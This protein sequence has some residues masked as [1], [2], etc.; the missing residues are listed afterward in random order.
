MEKATKP[1]G[2]DRI[3]KG[4]LIA[5]ACLGLSGCISLGGKAP[6][7]LFRLTA[8]ETA[9]A[10]AAVSGQLADAIVVLDP[11]ADRSLDVLRVPVRV[12]ASRLAYLKNAAWIEKPTRQFRSLLAETIRARTGKLVVE[13]GDYEV[14]GKTVI[15]GR[16]LRLGY[17]AQKRAVVVSFDAVR[18]DGIDGSQIATKRFEAVVNDVVPKAEAVGPALNAAA[19]DV[20]RQVSDWLA[21]E[22]PK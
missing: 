15:G 5:A 6:E 7:E 16:L 13:G 4:L 17:D 11:D 9:P 18:T 12:D 19:N 1:S 21:G 22:S 2:T 14:T 10:G 3:V 20:A 8:E